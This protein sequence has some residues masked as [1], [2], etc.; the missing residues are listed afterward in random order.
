[1]DIKVVDG[2]KKS[3]KN[4]FKN[5]RLHHKELNAWEF[6][7]NRTALTWTLPID[8]GVRRKIQE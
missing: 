8:I 7:R 3:D 2:C 6:I 5:Y 4:Y 1:M